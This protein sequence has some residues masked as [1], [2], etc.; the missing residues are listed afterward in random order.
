MLVIESVAGGAFPIAR[1][2]DMTHSDDQQAEHQ[3]KYL[4][5]PMKRAKHER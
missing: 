2:A 5:N 1:R 4:D 3:V